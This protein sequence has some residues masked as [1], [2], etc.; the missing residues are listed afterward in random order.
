MFK[1][2]DAVLNQET[3]DISKLDQILVLDTKHPKLLQ[4]K[5]KDVRPL[6]EYIF[7]KQG[8]RCFICGCTDATQMTLDHQHKRKFQDYLEGAGQIRGTLCRACNSVEG[9]FINSCKRYKINNPKLF[10]KNLLLYYNRGTYNVIH[11]SEKKQLPK[12]S[13]KQYNLLQQKLTSN[14]LKIPPLNK[15]RTLTKKL[16]ELFKSHNICPFTKGDL[17]TYQ[18]K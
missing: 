11:Y 17:K 9:K 15:K 13:K 8:N 2:I 1:K 3:L 10:L 12:I 18:L 16:Y 14:A 5:S 4:L 7:Q 6:R